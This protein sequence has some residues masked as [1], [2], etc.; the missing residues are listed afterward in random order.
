MENKWVLVGDGKPDIGD[1]VWV[2]IKS[3]HGNYVRP[4]TFVSGFMVE[5][6][7]CSEFYSVERDE[8]VGCVIG[9]QP[10]DKT[11]EP[12]NGGHNEK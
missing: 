11:P 1:S 12:L 6:E 8:Y 9:W 3:S 4:A 5:H 2:T 10:R 7:N